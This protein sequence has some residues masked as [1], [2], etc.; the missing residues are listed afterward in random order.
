MKVLAQEIDVIAYFTKEGKLEPLRFKFMNQERKVLVIKV[1][2]ILKEEKEMYC[3][4]VMDKFT[5]SSV[6]DN[7]ERI[8]ELKFAREAHKWIL[9]KY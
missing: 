9:F 6:I 2:K 5:C 7:I 8:Y 1:D 3:G 4:N